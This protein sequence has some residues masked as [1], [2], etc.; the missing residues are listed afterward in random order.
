VKAEDVDAV[1][2]GGRDEAADE[3]VVDRTRA[4]EEATAQ[5][6]AE[7]RLDAALSRISAMR[8]CSAVGRRP[9]RGSCPSSRTVVSARPGMRG[10]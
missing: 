2:G 5:R 6:E 8:S 9:A 1:R 3:V 7:R 4:D 10:A